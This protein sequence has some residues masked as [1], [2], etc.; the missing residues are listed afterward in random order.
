MTYADNFGEVGAHTFRDQVLAV[1][2]NPALHHLSHTLPAVRRAK[3]GPRVTYPPLLQFAV[4]I[5][6]RIYGSQRR[7]LLE[8]ADGNLWEEACAVFSDQTSKPVP[9]PTAPPSPRQQDRFIAWLTNEA[10]LLDRLS[11]AFTEAAVKQATFLGNFAE[12]GWPDYAHPDVWHTIFGDGTYLRPLSDAVLAVD[13][14]TNEQVLM[15]SRA[16]SP[17]RARV[18]EILTDGSEDQKTARGVNHVTLTTWTR[19]GWVILGVRQALGGEVHQA[20]DLIASVHNHLG[21][22]LHTVVWDRVIKGRDL[23]D[24]I[25]ER[26]LMIVTKPVERA[27][28]SL[29]S[30]GFTAPVVDA[31]EARRLHQEESPL[32]LGTCVYP[33]SVNKRPEVTRSSYYKYDTLTDGGC[34]HDLWVDDGALVDVIEARNGWLVKTQHAS[35]LHARPQPGPRFTLDYKFRLPCAQAPAGHHD[36]HRTW[37]PR[38]S[39]PTKGPAR[40]AYDLQPVPR[41][42]PETFN[43][44]HGLRNNTES[45]NAWFKATLGQHKRA[46]RVDVDHQRIDHL[47]AA[48]L[49]N[50]RTWARYEATHGE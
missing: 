2:G 13:P 17:A 14:V 34:T 15:G 35:V 20:R 25:S 10:G 24:F 19:C 26:R 1:F 36:F 23:Q 31:E 33:R 44:I 30:S 50:A 4:A 40:A 22:R 12:E 46:M 27:T 8:L 47:C 7:A 21:H 39:R 29:K 3:R 32:P 41:L 49:T 5:S 11:D 6:A 43:A 38:A 45:F 9:L 28:N 16:A 48:M 42:S 18:Q 37:E